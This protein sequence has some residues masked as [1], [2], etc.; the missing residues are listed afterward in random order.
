MVHALRKK[1]R[2]LADNL[3]NVVLHQDNAPSHT[4]VHTQ[5]EIDVLG[6]QRVEHPPYSPDLAPLDFAYFPKLKSHL[7][8]NHFQ[9][10]DETRYAIR[11][12]N[13][14]LDAEWYRGV[15]DKWV[16]R[17]QKCINHAGDYFEKE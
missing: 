15:Y 16:K 10:R 8:G 17:H 1:R 11:N 13:R 12:C 2:H 4:A 14:C 9:D 6:F 5:L 3:E 7:R